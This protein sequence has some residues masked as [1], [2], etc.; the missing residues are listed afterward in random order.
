MDDLRTMRVR[1][2]LGV[3]QATE[4]VR[5]FRATPSAPIGSDPCLA[6]ILRTTDGG[7]TWNYN[8]PHPSALIYLD[9]TG[10]ANNVVVS[11]VMGEA[12]SI[13]GGDS[14]NSSIGGGTAQCVRNVGPRSNPDALAAVGEFGLFTSKNG[15]AISSDGGIIFEAYDAGLSMD[16]RYGA[17]P[18]TS[19][20]YITAGDWPESNDDKAPT[21][22]NMA[23]TNDNMA[24]DIVF[25]RTPRLHVRR[26]GKGYKTFVTP[27]AATNNT[28]FECQ[29]TVSRDSGKTWTTVYQN[30]GDFYPNGIACQDEDNCCFVGESDGGPSP[31]ARIH[32]TNDGG[33]SWNQTLFL[34]GPSNSLMDIRITGTAG[35][36]WAVGGNLVSELDANATFWHSTNNGASWTLDS[37]ISG[38][39]ATAVDCLDSGDCWATTLQPLFQTASVARNNQ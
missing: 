1:A 11:G 5:G 17:F 35:E 28:I 24:H 39:Y 4:L 9:V 16:A 10:Y 31:G 34:S 29:V 3:S 38:S 27:S 7:K 32:C 8:E 21:N 30:L 23:P 22:D 6:E 12:F 14:F 36:Y 26:H 37:T 25:S 33:S 13:N 20:W 19:V 15:V 2:T 18:S